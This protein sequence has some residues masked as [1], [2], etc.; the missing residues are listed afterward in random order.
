[1]ETYVTDAKQRRINIGLVGLSFFMGI[2]MTS[3]AWVSSAVAVGPSAYDV[4]EQTL[5][6]TYQSADQI[7]GCLSQSID[8]L[9]AIK[10]DSHAAANQIRLESGKTLE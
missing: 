9:Q 8:L 5:K 10:D 4:A 6:T 3:V 1:M 7:S 2:V